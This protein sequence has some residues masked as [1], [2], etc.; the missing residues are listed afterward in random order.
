[1]SVRPRAAPAKYTPVYHYPA[2]DNKYPVIVVS[3][4]NKQNKNKIII[5]II[6]TII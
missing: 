2:V 4:W 1:M 3:S 5:I 6:I